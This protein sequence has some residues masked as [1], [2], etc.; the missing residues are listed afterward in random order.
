[1]RFD[2]LT[3]FPGM[4]TPVLN[5][6][7]IGRAVKRGIIE[8]NFVDIREFSKDK[9]KKTD[10]YPFGGGYGMVMTAQPI[11]DAWRSVAYM[12]DAAPDVDDGEKYSGEKTPAIRTIYLSPQGRPL[13]QKIALGLSR[14]PRLILLCGHYEGVDERAI[15]MIGAEEISIGDYV[16]TGGEIPAM[17]LIDCVSRMIPGV[18]SEED[19]IRNESHYEGR[20]EYP[21]YTRPAVFMGRAAPEALLNGNHAEIE[22]W[23]REAS[24]SRTR[25]KRPDMFFAQPRR[26]LLQGADNFRDMGGYPAQGGAVTR[27]GVFY[28]ADALN[29]LTTSDI[30]LLRDAGLT[31]VV[32]MRSRQEAER[33]PD[34]L[35]FSEEIECYNIPLMSESAIDKAIYEAPFKELY[36]T[37][38]EYG[39]KKI[40][41]VFTAMAKSRGACVFHCH[42]GKDRTGIIAALL[43]M[44]SGA[45]LGDVIADY[46]VSGT[47]YKTRAANY[48]F[49]VIELN[50]NYI[51][52]PPE[53]IEHFIKHIATKYGGAMQYLL[54]AGT[55]A[56][57]IAALKGKFLSAV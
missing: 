15:E 17:A 47:Y 38:A 7:V 54:A 53:N 45:C 1:M 44:L 19:A 9:H 37:F 3:L 35:A 39:K 12:L 48:D 46:E 31:T 33:A 52:S 8:L 28:R 23:R 4:F 51:G 50:T 10:D 16:L 41:K 30:N 18:L 55:S 43:L 40:A 49:G 13:T 32:D 57:D 21:Q 26:L 14:E 22:R 5:E 42:A 56:A 20:L 24:L 6:S 25:V 36:I 29:N 27:W 34:S 11:Y 2:V